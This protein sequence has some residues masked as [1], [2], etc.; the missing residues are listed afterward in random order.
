MNWLFSPILLISVLLSSLTV[1]DQLIRDHVP[2]LIRLSCYKIPLAYTTPHYRQPGHRRAVQSA[3]LESR[4]AFPFH[5]CIQGISWLAVWSQKRVTSPRQFI[6]AAK[7]RAPLH[8][9]VR[10][11]DKCA[12]PLQVKVLGCKWVRGNPSWLGHLLGFLYE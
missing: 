7:L 11:C 5:S 3:T 10:E 12:A 9:S 6:A 1:F 2:V 8:Y 4:A